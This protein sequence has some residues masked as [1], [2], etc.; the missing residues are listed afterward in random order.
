LMLVCAVSYF[1][2]YY[3][4]NLRINVEKPKGQAKAFRVDRIL[5]NQLSIK[6][7]VEEDDLP[8]QEDTTFRTVV[9]NFS[10]ANRDVQQV[11]D[12]HGNLKGII[13]LND[14][15]K[16]LSDTSNYDTILARDLMHPPS[17]TV[18]INEPA[19][20]VLDK[21]D[22]CKLWSLPVVRDGKFKGFISKSRLLTQYR[23]ELTRVNRFF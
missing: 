13:S 6:A 3:F 11:L 1:L 15:R 8:V 21:F 7:L 18:D 16:R 23:N 10:N 19:S 14:F 20:E 12:S 2:K 5:L 22:A 9:E 17:I 4:E